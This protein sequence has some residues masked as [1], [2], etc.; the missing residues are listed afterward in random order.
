MRRWLGAMAGLAVLLAP[1]VSGAADPSVGIDFYSAYVWRGITVQDTPVLQPWVDLSGIPLGKGASL[2]INLWGN[3]PVRDV[4]N[5]GVLTVDGGK[6]S[7]FDGTITVSL[8]K[9]FKAGFVE[10]TLTDNVADTGELFAGWTGSFGV[11]VSVNAYYDVQQVDGFYGSIAV[12]R[13]F[14]LMPKL[15]TNIEALAGYASENFSVNSTLGTKAGLCNYGLTGK[16]SYAPTEK[17]GVG[18]TLG[19][20]GHFDEHVLPEQPVSFYGGITASLAF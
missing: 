4:R 11:D 9:G 18:L 12:A 14:A 2:G 10:Y 19:Y 5:E 13:E 15:T 3:F 7:E 8:P 16:L 17:L 6:F 1:T 20:V